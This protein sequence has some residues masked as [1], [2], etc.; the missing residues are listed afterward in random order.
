VHEF[1]KDITYHIE[2]YV[3]IA[4]ENGRAVVKLN[5]VTDI[6]YTG[7]IQESATSNQMDRIRFGY[8]GYLTSIYVDDIIVDDATFPGDTRIQKITVNGTGTTTDWSPSAGA[9]YECVDEIP[10]DDT[11]YV[12][13]NTVNLIDLYNVSSLVGEVESVKCIQVQARAKKEGLSTPQNL[14]L[15]VKS[16]I[17]NDFGSSQALESDYKNFA[18]LWEVNPATSSAWTKAEIDDLEI[19]IK[20]IA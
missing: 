14:Q 3:L 7:D 5:G 12:Y 4:N 10:A 20:S 15:G 13:T 1:K 6:D 8:C 2:I 11:D 19:G 18:E 9:N 16:G 17:T